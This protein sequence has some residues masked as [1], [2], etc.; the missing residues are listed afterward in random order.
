M[1]SQESTQGVAFLT[2]PNLDFSMILEVAILNVRPNQGPDFEKAFRTAEPIVSSSRGYQHHELRRS[3]ETP[4]R[5]LLLVWWQDVESHR[6]GFR[7]S[8]QYERWKELLHHFYEPFPE[9]AYYEALM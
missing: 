9:V 6:V 3:L 1:A 4:T 2:N 7:G 8:T 5:Y